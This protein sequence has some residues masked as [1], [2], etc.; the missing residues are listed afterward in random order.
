MQS[1]LIE[2]E[3]DATRQTGSTRVFFWQAAWEMAKDYPFGAGYSGFNV[4]APQYI[5]EY[6]D[7]GRSANRSVH[8]TWFETL[9]EVGY[10]GLCLFVGLLY[11]AFS[12]T[13][14]CKRNLIKAGDYE[15]YHLVVA[16][17]AALL[18]F[19]V[20]MTFLDRMRAEVLYW[21][22]LYTACAYHLYVVVEARKEP[23]AQARGQS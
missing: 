19:M 22:I 11:S 2:S 16:M 9:S 21:L 12:C 10:L 18:C 8:S 6:V 7:T 3:L 5:P 17:Q 14:K 1:I 15:T 20:S 23:G 4:N 13:Q